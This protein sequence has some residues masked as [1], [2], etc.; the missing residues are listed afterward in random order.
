MS[1]SISTNQ[2]NV[3][4][5]GIVSTASFEGEVQSTSFWPHDLDGPKEEKETVIMSVPL[6]R[7]VTLSARSDTCIP[8]TPRCDMCNVPSLQF[9]RFEVSGYP[10]HSQTRDDHRPAAQ[11]EMGHIH[12]RTHTHA[13]RRGANLNPLRSVCGTAAHELSDGM[14]VDVCQP[15]S[16][17]N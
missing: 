2:L 1:S 13:P 6:P 16:H 12:V 7:H 11:T 14:R 5:L 17:S 15:H 9:A 3:K 8:N 10:H 4:L